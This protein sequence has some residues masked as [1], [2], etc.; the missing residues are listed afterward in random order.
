MSPTPAPWA[1]RREGARAAEAA[2]AV[3]ERR[4]ARRVRA[5]EWDIEAGSFG[6]GVPV[7]ALCCGNRGLP[8]GWRTGQTRASPRGAR[9]RYAQA[10]MGESLVS[11]LLNVRDLRVRF[12]G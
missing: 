3:P 4:K 7:A 2:K 6:L 5:A 11:P 9:L 8:S 12:A 1:R 10:G